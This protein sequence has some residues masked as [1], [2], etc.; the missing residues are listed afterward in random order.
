MNGVKPEGWQLSLNRYM[1][2]V[3]SEPFVWG[4]HDCFLFAMGCEKAVYGDSVFDDIGLVYSSEQE[5]MEIL[6]SYG[7]DNVFD[8]ANERLVQ[9][10]LEEAVFGDL[11]GYYANGIPA[12][13]VYS[14]GGFVAPA[15]KRLIAMP[16]RKIE[17]CW[18]RSNG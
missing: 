13:G 16:K 6:G 15:S 8:A 10:P 4:V 12:L 14:N 9:I 7:C 2:S 11:V 1:A 5:A 18:S 3:M 17:F